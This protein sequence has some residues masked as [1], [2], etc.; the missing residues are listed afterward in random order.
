MTYRPVAQDPLTP[1]R[2]RKTSAVGPANAVREAVSGRLLAETPK[3]GASAGLRR[4]PYRS[5]AWMGSMSVTIVSARSAVM[6]DTMGLLRHRHAAL[7][8]LAAKS[9]AARSAM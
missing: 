3:A 5:L 7:R 4:S 6:W 8:R 1:Q 2:V 9:S